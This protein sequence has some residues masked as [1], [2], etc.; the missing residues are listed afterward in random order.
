MQNLKRLFR[1][2]MYKYT[3]SSNHYF[4]NVNLKGVY[5][6]SKYFDCLDGHCTIYKGYSWD[7]CSFVKDY[8]ETY[9]ASLEHD[10]LYQYGKKLGIN[11]KVC[12]LQFYRTMRKY[13]FK[14]RKHYYLGVRL[15]GWIFY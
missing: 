4:Y 5:F 8:A 1:R 6:T 12:D 2:K 15:F 11:R 9:I 7:G 10:A 3:L 14:K 13:D